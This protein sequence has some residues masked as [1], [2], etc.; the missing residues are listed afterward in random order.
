[1]KTAYEAGDGPLSGR[2]SM[3][4]ITNARGLMKEPKFV[5]LLKELPDLGVELIEN[6]LNEENFLTYCST[7]A[8]V[9]HVSGLV[10]KVGGETLRAC[11]KCKIGRMSGYWDRTRT[12]LP[13]HPPLA[14]PDPSNPYWDDWGKKDNGL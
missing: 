13:A 4:C 11:A 12:L 3:Y 1:M 7:C 5:Q 10:P 9:M 6:L 8:H 14:D 2:I